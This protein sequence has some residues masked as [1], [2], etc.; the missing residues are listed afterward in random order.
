[1]PGHASFAYFFLGF[2]SASSSVNSG[3]GTVSGAG[4]GVT[5]EREMSGAA[6]TVTPAKK[7]VGERGVRAVGDIAAPSIEKLILEPMC[8]RFYKDRL[9]E[10]RIYRK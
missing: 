8:G 9:L 6:F 7:D 1:M 10:M 3:A 5:G 4:G 2:T